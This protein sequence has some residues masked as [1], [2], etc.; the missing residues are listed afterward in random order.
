MWRPV[1]TTSGPP[2]DDLALVAADGVLVQLGDRQVLEAGPA[3]VGERRDEGGASG[4][5]R[6]PVCGPR[7][8]PRL[9]GPDRPRVVRIGWIRRS[10]LPQSGTRL[11]WLRR[12]ILRRGTIAPRSVARPRNGS[13]SP[14]ARRCARNSSTSSLVTTPAGRPSWTATSAEAPPDKRLERLVQRRP[15]VDQ[16]QRPIHHL[17]HRAL[18]HGRVAIRPLQQSLL[19]DRAHDPL[20]QVVVTLGDRHLADAVA[21]ERARSRPPRARWSG[22]G[23][24]AA[25]PSRGD[26]RRAPSRPAP[27]PTPRPAAP[28]LRI[29]S[30]SYSLDR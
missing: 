18:D 14:P 26:A 16:G 3:E 6:P 21:L 17:A 25:G 12:T 11:V 8:R 1:R 19:V 10:R 15:E 24:P 2:S 4:H 30:S 29:H 22:P 13:Q 27:A 28:F 20:H 5:R 7:P 9:Q 23:P